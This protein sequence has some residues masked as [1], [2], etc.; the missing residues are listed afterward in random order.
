[1]NITFYK[2]FK[3]YK[4]KNINKINIKQIGYNKF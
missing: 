2:F 1:M 3:E 4:I